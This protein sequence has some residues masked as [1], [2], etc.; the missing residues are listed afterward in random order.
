MCK[1]SKEQS[2]FDGVYE[3]VHSFVRRATT[4][5]ASPAS[6][7]LREGM[8]LD[9][10]FDGVAI[11]ISITTAVRRLLVSVTQHHAESYPA[12]PTR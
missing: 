2:S 11:A 9:L 6:E 7:L 3:G 8:N 5:A 4:F 10:H 1:A 12:H